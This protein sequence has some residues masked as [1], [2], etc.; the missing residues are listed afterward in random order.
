MGSLAEQDFTTTREQI[1]ALGVNRAPELSPA[2]DRF[3]GELSGMLAQLFQVF[4]VEV[5]RAANDYPASSSSSTQGL[6]NFA[7]AIGLSNFDGGYGPRGATFA[8]GYAANLTGD[9]GT[10]YL[11]GQQAIVGGVTLSLR[12]GVVIPGVSGSGQVPGTWDSLTAGIAGNLTPGTVL[13]L[14]SPPG[15]SDP[16]ITLLTGPSIAGQDAE[17]DSSIL[18]RILNKTKRPPNGGNPQDY[19]DWSEGA[20]DSAGNPVTTATLTAFVYPN[21]YGDGFPMAVVLQTGSGTERMITIL[22]QQG[23]Q[24]YVNGTTTEDG[25]RPVSAPET[26]LAGYFSPDR[27]LTIR[28]RTVP[29]LPKFAF[30]WVRGVTAYS[31]FGFQTVA[32]PAFVTA[33]GG[34]AMLELNALAPISLKDAI[35]ADSQPIVQVDTRT[36]LTI[37]GPV[38]PEQWP[39]LAFLDALG[40]TQLALKVPNTANALAWVQ[41]TNPVFSGSV[42]V[43]TIAGKILTDAVDSAGP[44][45]AS[46]LADRA[47]TWQDVVGST[48]VSTAAENALDADGITRIITRCIAGGVTIAIGN[49]ATAVQ[50]VT[51]SDNTING[52][53]ILYAGRILVT[54]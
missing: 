12:T 26:V 2:P 11:A 5:T 43:A 20:L 3:L 46:G 34:N 15:T 21:Y 52:P 29:S 1:A 47:A 17:S 51:A 16:Q 53:E 24:R 9:V 45:R 25:Q 39:C 22:V 41:V 23:I 30:D 27:A 36:A 7:I 6:T 54:D 40:R 14:Q 50:D 10:A 8:Q 35:A 19:K 33:A 42:Y 38:V 13:A 4:S 44:S 49:A 28:A 18:T 48:T 37:L 32:L 31:V